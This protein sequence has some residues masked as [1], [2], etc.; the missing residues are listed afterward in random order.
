M[1]QPWSGS[2]IIQHIKESGIWWAMIVNIDIQDTQIGGAN[3]VLYH[4]HAVIMKLTKLTNQ[5][6]PAHTPFLVIA[7]MADMEAIG[8]CIST[9]I[10][11]STNQDC[12]LTKLNK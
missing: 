5:L 4:L 9:Q 12:G 10:C 2:V 1:G 7:N 3:A 6:I 11:T 8:N